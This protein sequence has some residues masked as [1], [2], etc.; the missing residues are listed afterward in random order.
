MMRS[1]SNIVYTQNQSIIGQRGGASVVV[2]QNG[3][4][5]T[6]QQLQPLRQTTFERLPTIQSNLEKF[7]QI[8]RQNQDKSRQNPHQITPTA[9]STV[10]CILNTPVQ[11]YHHNGH[12]TSSEE[13]SINGKS[14]NGGH[15]AMSSQCKG[16]MVQSADSYSTPVLQTTNYKGSGDGVSYSNPVSNSQTTYSTPAIQTTNYNSEN[17]TVG[18]NYSNP[19]PVYSNPGRQM[20]SPRRNELKNL[21][22]RYPVGYIQQNRQNQPNPPQVLL[23]RSNPPQPPACRQIPYGKQVVSMESTPFLT[24]LRFC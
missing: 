4:Q 17:A 3:G 13:P 6:T 10:P 9:Q 22:W 16:F 19:G 18:Y 21:P 24:D 5:R 20:G 11:L 12:L 7:Q 14:H 1:Q 2:V 8:Q 23:V 15:G